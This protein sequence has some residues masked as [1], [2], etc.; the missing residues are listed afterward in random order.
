MRILVAY[1]RTLTT[2]SS[3]SVSAGVL[4]ARLRDAGHQVRIAVLERGGRRDDI[5]E[6]L[7]ESPDAV[8]MKPNFKDAG[9]LPGNLR[10]IRERAGRV[11]VF[12][13]GPFAVLDADRLLQAFPEVAAILLPDHEALCARTLAGFAGEP[14]G[15][16]SGFIVRG[17]GSPVVMRAEPDAIEAELWSGGPARDVERQEPI[18]LANIEASRGCA[19]SCSFCHVPAFG[20]QGMGRVSR[21]PVPSLI[22]EIDAL[23]AMGKRYLIF[24]DPILGGGGPDGAAYL[25]EL[26]AALRGRSGRMLFMA[27]LTLN[28]IERHREEVLGLIE[29]GLARVFIGVESADPAGA[30]RLRKGVRVETYGAVKRWLL[31]RDVV[32]HIGFML[33]HP[34]ATADEIRRG[35]DFLLA[36]DEMHRFGVVRE[37]TR[38]VPGTP[39]FEEVARAGL[40]M[41]PADDTDAWDYRFADPA[42]QAAH[43]R[44]RHAFETIGV[45]LLERLEHLFVSAEFLGN[46][47]ARL[48]IEPGWRSGYGRLAQRRAAFS[49]ALHEVGTAAL[50]ARPP[51]MG[52]PGRFRDLRERAEEDWRDFVAG[53]E[54]CGLQSP[55]DWFTT[56]DLACEANRPQ[57]YTGRWD[58]T[59]SGRITV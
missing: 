58:R 50:D 23:A 56:G 31:A 26:A 27:Y 24:N 43:A 17:D 59:R 33:F 6:F 51:G 10:A 48:E 1:Y 20:R 15:P 11:P 34:F 42:V 57:G 55:L 41:R 12:L 47:A 39:L 32:P 37:R 21:R 3:A 53:L 16:G 54:A 5:S 30:R 7:E 45:A 44:F 8:I 28:D 22:E 2:Q 4:A 19:R 38:L 25:R 46:I 13:Y 40:A 36:E 14:G 52:M 18:L 35:L 9:R 29:A 49:S